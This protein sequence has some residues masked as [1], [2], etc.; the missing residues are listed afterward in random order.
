MSPVGLCFLLFFSVLV[1]HWE[2][3]CCYANGKVTRACGSMK[4]HHG[5]AS[6]QTTKSPYQLQTNTSTF[7]PGDQI[8]EAAKMTKIKDLSDFDNATG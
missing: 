6:G 2:P 1:S 3:G 4:P 8:K 7:S 5:G